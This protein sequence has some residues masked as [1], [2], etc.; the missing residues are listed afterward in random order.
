MIASC[1]ALLFASAQIRRDLPAKTIVLTYHDVIPS[2]DASSLW[3]DCSSS[4]LEAQ[5]TW[6]ERHGAHFIKLGDLYRHLTSG[7]SLPPHP[8][9]I[10]F[11]DNYLGFWKYGYPVLKRHHVPV[12][13]FVHTGFVGSQ[14][15]RPK[16]TW[17]QLKALERDGLFSVGSQTVTHAPD[18]KLLSDAQLAT[19]M[20]ASKQVLERQLG[21]AIAFVAYPNGK[22]DRRAEREAEQAGY[23][24]GMS[25]VTK[26]AE[27]SPDIFAVNRY[28]HTKMKQAWAA[29][30]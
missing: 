12:T 29:V 22:F 21:H 8:V 14:V 7:S 9:A 16:M 13:M 1:V 30:H 17:T 28:V 20:R 11:A 24:M 10:T 19:E 3:F 15:G 25:E 2:R 6:M 26:P 5:L 18:L 27:R 23:L 4:E